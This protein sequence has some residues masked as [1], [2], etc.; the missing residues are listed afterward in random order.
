MYSNGES[1]RIIGRALQTFNIPRHKVVIMTKCYRVVCDSENHD[2]SSG[3][4]M[5]HDLADHSKDYVNQWGEQVVLHSW[6]I[7]VR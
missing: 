7:K 6:V 2:P 1:E 5:H 3:V 4:T